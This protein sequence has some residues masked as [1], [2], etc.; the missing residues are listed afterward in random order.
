LSPVDFLPPRPGLEHHLKHQP[1]VAPWATFCRA[2]G[3]RPWIVAP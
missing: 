1:T 3:A 2:S